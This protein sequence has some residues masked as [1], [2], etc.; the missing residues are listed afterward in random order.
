[1]TNLRN[2]NGVNAFFSENF[3]F[4]G[5]KVHEN[6]FSERALRSAHFTNQ[7]QNQNMVFNLLMSQWNCNNF[8]SLEI[9]AARKKTMNAIN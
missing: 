3:N 2:T 4:K 7:I 1:M 9:I 6:K 5:K 8:C